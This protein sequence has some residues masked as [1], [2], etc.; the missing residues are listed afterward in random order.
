MS[1]DLFQ[2][3]VKERKLLETLFEETGGK[4]IAFE[5]GVRDPEF[6]QFITSVPDTEL[7]KELIVNVEKDYSDSKVDI[8]IYITQ[9]QSQKEWQKIQVEIFTVEDP[10]VIYRC[11]YLSKASQKGRQLLIEKFNLSM[12]SAEMKERNGE[13]D[14]DQ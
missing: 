6:S 1:F 12:K 8:K 10:S 2:N 13:F 9:L 7:T 11:D 4:Y 5:K 3:R 14:I